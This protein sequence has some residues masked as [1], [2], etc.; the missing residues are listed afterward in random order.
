MKKQY[1]IAA[2]AALAFATGS[3]QADS[4][5]TTFAGGN[6]CGGGSMFDVV[7]TVPIEVTSF[8][9]NLIGGPGPSVPVS[10]YYKVGT[11]AGFETNSGAWT[12]LGSTTVTS[13]GEGNPTPVP[14]G[15]LSI[16][17]D[18]TYGIYVNAN[19]RYSNGSNT[20]DNGTVTL[21]NGTGLCNLF[22]GTNSNRVWNGTMY[23]DAAQEQEPQA[24]PTLANFGLLAL[25][26]A[27]GASG[28]S[29]IRRRAS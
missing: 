9:Q 21:T 6:G 27:L 14:I 7:S 2:V 8:D 15:G 3:V 16:P 20:Y 10:V 28:L 17:A 1:A 25:I 29:R 12:L 4:I 11:F 5:T 19:V 13:Q 26:L 18:T 23:Y 24:V 22:S